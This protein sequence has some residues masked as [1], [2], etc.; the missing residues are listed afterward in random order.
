MRYYS[1]LDINEYSDYRSVDLSDIKNT[2]REF[3]EELIEELEK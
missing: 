3:V 2:I 1:S